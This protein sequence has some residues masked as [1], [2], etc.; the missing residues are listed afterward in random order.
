[1]VRS[2]CAAP[3]SGRFTV[4]RTIGLQNPAQGT[5]NA[6][7]SITWRVTSG[8]NRCVLR[9]PACGA[10]NLKL[11]RA[12]QWTLIARAPGVPGQWLAF[13]LRRTYTAR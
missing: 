2:T 12:G 11:R 13:E 4:G 5:T 3:P 6:D 10:V 9:F 8:G 1:M 7:E